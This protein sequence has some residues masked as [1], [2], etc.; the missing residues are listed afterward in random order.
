MSAHACTLLHRFNTWT[1]PCAIALW[2]TLPAPPA[3]AQLF[4]A[5]D[6]PADQ[7]DQPL[8]AED[9]EVTEFM[10]VTLHVQDT[11]LVKVL[12]MLSIQSQRNILA[13][14]DVSATISADLYDVSFYDALDALLHVNGYGW[15]EEG[16]F[17]YVYTLE[18]IAQI[19]QANR[20]P[21][22]KLI[23]LNY[24]SAADAAVFVTP[25]LSEAGT[26]AMNGPVASGISVTDS[27]V[28][29]D[30]YAWSG[31]LVVSD[32]AENVEEIER[33]ISQLD[34]RPAQVL[35]E[36]TIL[37]TTLTEANAFG[38]D[39]SIIA[40]VNFVD[41]IGGPLSGVGA[42]QSG[43]TPGANGFVPPDG[44][45]TAIGTSVG[46]TSGP[47]GLKI[48]V[49]H[50]EF[51]I[52][53]KVLDEVTDSVILS[54]PKILCLNRQR[55]RV[56]VGRNIGY[57]S[58][59]A[60]DTST[61]QT[62]EFLPTG[63][64]LA[65][66]PFISNDGMIRM[67]LAPRVSE[68]VI[69]DVTNASGA[70]VTIPDEITQELTT[71]VLVRDGNTIVLGGLFRETTT[72]SRRQVPFLGDLPVLGAAFRGNED[73]TN[74]SEIIFMIRP[75]IVND[76]VLV[77]QAERAMEYADQAR[78]GA[79][80]G[81]LIW[82]RERL[83]AGWNKDAV[84]YAQEGDYRKALW[85]VNRSLALDPTQPR[86]I[87]LREKFMNEEDR[88]QN[89]SIL[90]DTIND[91][92]QQMID[93]F[94]AGVAKAREEKMLGEAR[95]LLAFEQAQAERWPDHFPATAQR[96]PSPD[97]EMHDAHDGMVKLAG[98]FTDTPSNDVAFTDKTG[99]DGFFDA[100]PADDGDEPVAFETTHETESRTASAEFTDDADSV[101]F[102]ERFED[103]SFTD[104]SEFTDADEFTDTEQPGAFDHFFPKEDRFDTFED[105]DGDVN[106]SRASSR[107]DKT[108]SFRFQP[109]DDALFTAVYLGEAFGETGLG[110]VMTY[111]PGFAD[112]TA[113]VVGEPFFESRFDFDGTMVRAGRSSDRFMHAEATADE[114]QTAWQ[115][116]MGFGAVTWF[117]S[118]A[119]AVTEVPTGTE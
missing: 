102:V 75:T 34:T 62:V 39:F 41:F 37:Q 40:D 6:E 5:G 47:G 26:I 85:A 95:Q 18:E 1:I 89:R 7:T 8:G 116:L 43:A 76:T 87:A 96:W 44:R 69:R 88:W 70:T 86:A 21:V 83:T 99:S 23:N 25:A 108:T 20:K 78:T 24:I 33:I 105:G 19:E 98:D 93:E 22:T 16:N 60:T 9:I 55:A 49:I 53:M 68:G 107:F 104:D 59:T 58:T 97:V 28:G 117:D 71:N 94:G 114:F 56:Q 82:S 38:V 50:D 42:L 113:P 90:T 57:L 31:V 106:V 66:R 14:Q 101:T 110:F 17:I 15:I 92:F 27:D 80:R 32:Y 51:S 79:R 11:E 81:T 3:D 119:E 109:A 64:T 45:G 29:E 73:A 30:S 2:A 103:T 12:Q 118:P 63:T 74:R 72:L 84:E 115:P 4:G 100:G 61:T 52:F 65:F 112:V 35:V 48:G 46:Q 77:E 91:G 67:E 13:S 54:N 111:T 10:E 36:A